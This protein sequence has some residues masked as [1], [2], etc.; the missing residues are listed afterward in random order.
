M[1]CGGVMELR[2]LEY[3][4]VV[5]EQGHLG[6]AAAQLRLSQPAL[7]KSLKRLEDALEVRLFRRSANGMELT[8]EGSLLLLRA[9]ELRDSLR[10]V[11]REV[12][13][14]SKGH[15]GHINV[16][17]GPNANDEFLLAA[18]TELL[19][20]EP[21]ITLKV[22]VSDQDEIIPALRRGE[23]DVV[24]NLVYPK[25]P[26]GLAYI[27]LRED[28]CVVCCGP[29]HR[30]AGRSHVTLAELSDERWALGEPG[31]PTQQILHEVLR[32]HGMEPPRAALQT[33]LL[34]LRLQAAASSNLLL[35]TS[36][37]IAQ[38]FGALAVLPVEEL[39]SVRSLGVLHRK[40]P[41]LSPAIRR[42]IDILKAVTP[43]AAAR[44]RRAS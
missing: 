14:V 44:A 17:V 22:I 27:D 5:A 23:I 37:A 13:D 32:D 25:P 36:K 41:Y 8:A 3:F 15:A 10:N 19:R 43:G 12:A 18:V 35:Y 39:R 30:L 9:R 29:N 2:D 33:R 24:V 6:R 26:T 4:V 40:E 16:G 34:S 28:E 21:R 42:F 7:S 20:T 38:Q 1:N 11:V 31:L